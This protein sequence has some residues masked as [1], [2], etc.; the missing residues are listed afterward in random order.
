[1]IIKPPKH[2][3]MLHTS[4]YVSSCSIHLFLVSSGSASNVSTNNLKCSV[5]I[6]VSRCLKK[7]NEE[8]LLSLEA[9]LNA[10]ESVYK[11]TTI[12][13][14]DVFVLFAFF[15]LTI[16]IIYIWRH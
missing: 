9:R 12:K 16:A 13:E 5:F 2:P 4:S 3:H 8:H 6:S 14:S 7:E 15:S 1:L 11:R 10:D